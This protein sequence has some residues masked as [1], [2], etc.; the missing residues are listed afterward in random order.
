MKLHRNA[1]STPISRQLLVDR[2]LHQGWTLRRRRR[3]RRREP[4]DRRQV[5]AAISAGRRRRPRR[6]ARR[7]RAGRAHQTP[8]RIGRADPAAARRRTGCRRGRSAGPCGVP[9]STVSAWL[10]RLGLNRPPAAP[11]GAGAALRVA[12]GGRPGAS[13]HQAARAASAS[14]APR[15]WRSPA[16]LAGRRLGVRARRGRRSH[17]AGLRRGLAR[18]ARA[19]LRARFSSGPSRGIGRAASPAQRVLTDNG[20]GYRVA[21]LSRRLRRP[22]PAPSA[23]AA[24]HAAHQRQGGAL[25][26]DAAARVGLRRALRH[27]PGAPAGAPPLGAVLQPR[28]PT[29][30]SRL[31]AAAHP[32][33]ESCLMNNVFETRDAPRR[34]RLLAGGE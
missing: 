26:P 31:S 13:R 21:R 27:V 9:R 1:R 15:A 14:R 17:A 30:Q 11:A 4:A 28:A 33:A 8:A 7:G 32:A 25:H 18:P 29:R 10:R 34:G 20:S 22:R 2:V 12:D 16:V 24:L 5:G 3:G 23:H 6:T 19:G